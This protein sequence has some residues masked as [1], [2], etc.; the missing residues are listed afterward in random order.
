MTTNQSQ[1]INPK[2]ARE[3]FLLEKFLE[4]AAL[5]YHNIEER[6]APDF[7]VTLND[8]RVGMELTE[9]F[10]PHD[11]VGA[12]LQ[13]QESAADRI[14]NQ[15]RVNYENAGGQP[16]YV[17]VLFN[18][19]QDLTR[20]NRAAAAQELAMFVR[21]ID[22][23]EGSNQEIR[24]GYPGSPFAETIASIR[25]YGVPSQEMALWTVLRAGWAF[26][27]AIEPI[28]ARI[29]EKARRLNSY[30][31]VVSS[32]WLVIVADATRPSQL[33][34]ARKSEFDVTSIKSSFDR[35]FFFGYPE[36]DVIEFARTSSASP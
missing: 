18:P 13:A 25:V 31:N 6:E 32:N 33:F 16:A 30:R 22:V 10:V 5:P 19:G 23:Q 35:T 28:Q 8:Q 12:P 26:P 24:P 1:P 36:R 2:K 29:D 4:C 20:L 15:A 27:I 14:V 34:T 17:R 3:R 21:D 11:S 7:I 9:L